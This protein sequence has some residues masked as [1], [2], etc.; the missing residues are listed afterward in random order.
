MPSSFAT[1]YKHLSEEKNG[2]VGFDAPLTQLAYSQVILLTYLMVMI[3]P[4]LLPLRQL[5]KSFYLGSSVP[6]M[7]GSQDIAQKP[8]SGFLGNLQALLPQLAHGSIQ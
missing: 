2:T 4:P 3:L 1:V 5:L 8:K 6:W 7:T